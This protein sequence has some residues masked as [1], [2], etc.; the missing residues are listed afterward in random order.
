MLWISGYSSQSIHAVHIDHI[1]K[2]YCCTFHILI[3][4]RWYCYRRSDTLRVSRSWTVDSSPS[5]TNA[6]IAATTKSKH[7]A[8][9]LTDSSIT[10]IGWSC[11]SEY[12][13]AA[14]TKRGTVHV[15]KL[16]DAEWSSRIDAGAEGKF[17]FRMR[18]RTFDQ[19]KRSGL[20]KAE[21]APDGRTILCFSEWG[22]SRR[23]TMEYCSGLGQLIIF[24]SSAK[25]YA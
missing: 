7:A 2:F 8:A 4:S 24:H 10:H 11:D 14:C 25:R 3:C 21:W 23:N 15:F 13:L 20:V 17:R 19:F 18:F 5:P 16:R 22:V 9:S 6:L 1:R 12:I